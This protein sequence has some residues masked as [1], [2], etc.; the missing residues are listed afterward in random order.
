MSLPFFGG[1]YTHYGISGAA[2]VI[3]KKNEHQE[4]TQ[5]R[6]GAEAM[7]TELYSHLEEASPS[8]R[9]IFGLSLDDRQSSSLNP[10]CIPR[11]QET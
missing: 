5:F 2:N 9:D 3:H 7:V 6:L 11:N 8:D 1:R 10:Y 4:S